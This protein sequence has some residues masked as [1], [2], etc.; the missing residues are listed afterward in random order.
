MPLG[1]GLVVHQSAFLQPGPGLLTI[2]ADF[3]PEEVQDATTDIVLPGFP[4]AS[5]GTAHVDDQTPTI[6]VP[7]LVRVTGGRLSYHLECDG[8][9]H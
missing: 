8:F 5:V 3:V 4:A 1:S 7:E 6:S 9:Q 2:K